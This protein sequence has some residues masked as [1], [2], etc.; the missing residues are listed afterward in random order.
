MLRFRLAALW[1]VILGAATTQAQQYP[2]RSYGVADGL[3]QLDVYEIVED[4]QGYAWFGTEAGLARFD[5][6]TFTT[7]TVEDGLPS[8]RINALV[9]CGN[10]R[11]WAATSHG[12]AVFEDGRF[13]RVGEGLIERAKHMAAEGQHVWISDG[14][15]GLH[16]IQ[17]L[18]Q[19]EP[20]GAL[21]K[22]DGLPSDTVLAMTSSGT[23]AWVLTSA[24]L[25]YL[26]E[27]RVARTVAAGLLPAGPFALAPAPQSGVWV[28]GA[29][30]LA[31]VTPE[32]QVMPRPFTRSDG[33]AKARTLATDTKDRVWVGTETG[34]VARFDGAASGA[35]LGIRF[36]S[37]NGLPAVPIT[38]LHIG[39]TGEV[40]IGPRAQGA[41]MLPNEAFAH[42]DATSG[43]T[44]PIVWYVAEID[45]MIWTGTDTGLFRLNDAARFEQI[46][47]PWELNIN[48]IL[49]HP[50]GGLWLGTSR[51][52]IHYRGP[53]R[54]QVMTEN[55]GLAATSILMLRQDAKGNLWI[56]TRKGV[57]LRRPDGTMQSWTTKD[58]LQDGFVNDMALD[59]A[60]V[61]WIATNKG[62]ARIVGSRVEPVSTGHDG[63]GINVLAAAPDGS[64]WGGFADHGL[65]HF[66]PGTTR[67]PALH[68]L[69]G[70]LRGA[71]TY[72]LS[73]G[74]KGELW[75]GTNRGIARF[76]LRNETLGEALPFTLY[77]ASRGFMAV[78]A[79]QGAALW[80]SHGRL[81][82]GTPSGL[83]CF[84]PNALPTARPPRLHLDSLRLSGGTDWHAFAESTDERG[85]PVGLQLPP[86]L[87]Y[88][89]VAFTGIDLGAPKGL[90]YQY[91]LAAG[92]EA[93]PAEWSPLVTS[94]TALFSNLAPGRYTFHVRAQSAD[95]LWT[96]APERLA[97][98][99]TPPFWRTPWFLASAVL[100]L[101]GLVLGIYNRKTALYRVRQRELSDAV[102]R[103]TA[104]L[105]AEKERVEATNR[106][107]GE[108]NA[109]LDRARTEALAAAKAKSEFLATMSHEIRTPLN[110]VI[111]MTGH[112]LDTDLGEEQ[113]EFASVIRSS[114]EGLLAIIN[115]VLDFSKIEAGML[116]LEEQPFEVRA[117][118]ED[119][120]DLVAHR[121]A[122][123]RIE[124]AYDV[125]EDVPY[126]ASGD[127]TRLR[128]IVV[129]LLS[130]AVKFTDTG[131]VVLTAVPTSDGALHVA[132]RDTGIGVAQDRL[133]HLF[134]E[135]T[136]ADTSTTRRY[137]GTGLGLS[138][139]K[140]LTEAMGGTIA[141]ESEPG[142]G[143]TFS[144]T[145]PIAALPDE[146]PPLPCRG[147]TSLADRRVLIVDDNDTN[148][149][150][151]A[152]QTT[153][154]GG[155]SVA[156]PSAAAALALIDAGETFDLAFLDFHMP[157][158]DGAELAAVLAE[159][160][161]SLPLVMLSSVQERPRVASGL[162]AD[163]LLKPVKPSQLCRVAVRVL[164]PASEPAVFLSESSTDMHA[165]SPSSPAPAA[166]PLRILVAEDNLVNQRVIG[167]ALRRLGYRADMVA[168]GEEALDALHR[169]AY[170]VVLMDLRM[171]RLDGLEATRRLRADAA[172]TQPRVI[173]MTA[174]V[175]SD[176]REAC[177]AAGMD[178]FLG[179]PI[180]QEAFRDA[181]SRVAADVTTPSEDAPPSAPVAF[182]E[183]LEQAGGDA[184]FY[185]SLLGDLHDSL[186]EEVQRVVACLGEN[187]AESAG[188]AA[189]SIKTL[190]AMLG[191]DTLVSRA[192]TMQDACDAENLDAAVTVLLPFN[193]A[194]R[195]VLEAVASELAESGSAP[196]SVP[197]MPS[198]ARVTNGG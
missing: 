142:V 59:A 188:R 66:A 73:F 5:G 15:H 21:T 104:E 138:I 124:L 187:D 155:E 141:A 116:E 64:I 32:G 67:N 181:L 4:A 56:G 77:D 47:L 125:D 134:E 69:A 24:G 105:R 38:S 28:L 52:L 37:E 91:G 186:A 6:L 25:A 88:L 129:N 123:K 153:K 195:D 9:V 45:E 185:G 113:F 108:T 121:A 167:L 154:W 169:S 128:Q 183:L 8:N 57:T 41:W 170:D 192:K 107:L 145:V 120:L 11:L 85:L 34:Q 171:P 159:R 61:P 146:R 68:P 79:N 43:L 1:F 193:G 74:P 117:C 139:A 177:F 17:N 89:S 46:A 196:C 160:C 162:L 78:E 144:I 31:H 71:T 40:W 75:A 23:R 29:Q 14:E 93:E 39:Q 189:H 114:G 100:G 179:K 184:E 109:A 60:G 87:N 112:L 26:A 98:T 136:Q 30:G 27:G 90:R 55:D 152:L 53:G 97:F 19:R 135:F 133:V 151:L 22:A 140:Q 94:K 54:M 166:F 102:E 2:L 180:D 111:G 149:R 176:K 191:A 165:P 44:D 143:S 42:F 175:T 65:M 131:E 72:S 147:A 101:L 86:E 96:P 163:S 110:G 82:V 197:A 190:G 36:S 157:D 137:G 48:S 172:L 20:I 182:P 83:T 115:D 122:E 58:G 95:G 99:I 51:G 84:D 161:P 158:M 118:F 148:R 174:D 156:V 150:I 16:R 49:P 103:R 106:Q 63:L 50:D 119:A 13:E 76:D 92:G 35:P 168:D 126:M 18:K 10:D 7:Y 132:V 12:V 33:L 194:A 198:L 81:W 130:N 173:A 178:G 3:P 70:R 80:D 62:L 164:Q 127:A